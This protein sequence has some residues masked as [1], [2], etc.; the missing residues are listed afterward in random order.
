M[1]DTVWYSLQF[2]ETENAQ[3]RSAEAIHK[4]MK[5]LGAI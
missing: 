5:T 1:T 4:H 2:A 3:W